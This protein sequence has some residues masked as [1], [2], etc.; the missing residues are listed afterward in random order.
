MLYEV[1]NIPESVTFEQLDSVISFTLNALDFDC[2]SQLVIEFDDTM[3][4]GQCGFFEYDEDELLISISHLLQGEEMLR[5]IIHELVHARQILTGQYVPGEGRKAGTWEGVTY[6]CDYMNLPW[7]KEAYAL[8]ET[9][10]E[11]YRL[12]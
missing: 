6:D 3:E 2:D 11:S 10:Y 4:V 8:E 5:T 12:H 7:E 1:E 9:I